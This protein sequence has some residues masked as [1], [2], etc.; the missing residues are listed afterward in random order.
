MFQLLL[1]TQFHFIFYIKKNNIYIIHII[2]DTYILGFKIYPRYLC[3]M[4]T[5]RSTELKIGFGPIF[6]FCKLFVHNIIKY[7]DNYLNVVVLFQ[8]FMGLTVFRRYHELLIYI[9]ISWIF[10]R[11]HELLIYISISW[12]FRRYHDLLIYIHISWIFRRY[13]DYWYI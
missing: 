1:V 8:S 4:Y 5:A 7:T 2:I 13:H 6:T 10:R 3:I 12:I 11:Y 9:S